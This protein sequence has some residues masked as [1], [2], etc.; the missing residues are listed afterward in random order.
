MNATGLS[1][2]GPSVS[3]SGPL[4]IS[5]RGCNLI[6]VSNVRPEPPAGWPASPWYWRMAKLR[7][8]MLAPLPVETSY[9]R[10]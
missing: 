3:Q 8:L 1:Q 7:S 10:G 9:D 6:T 2:S 5:A 4:R